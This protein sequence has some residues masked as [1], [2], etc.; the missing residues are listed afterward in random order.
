[1]CW[2]RAGQLHERVIL[3]SFI[4]SS[5]AESSIEYAEGRHRAHRHDAA[6]RQG[7]FRTAL[8]AAAL[9]FFGAMA[10]Q[11]AAADSYPSRPITLVVGFPP[12][13]GSDAVARVLGT[14][15]GAKLGQPIVVDNKPGAN[16]LIATQFVRARPN[17]GYTLLF[18]S[19]SFAINPSL[20]KVNY[21]IAKDFAPIALVG[22]VPLVFVANN[23]VPV[24]TVPEVVALLKAKPGQLT[25]ASFGSGSVAHLATEQFLSMTG[26]Q[27]LHVPYK[28]SAQA[29][30]DVMGGQVPFMM[31]TIGAAASLIKEGKLRAIGVSGA[32]RSPSLPNVPTIAESGV[33][34]FNLVT[35]ESVQAPAGTDP[36]IVA[37]LNAAIREVLSTAE[38][39]TQM[40]NLGLEAE[41]R[42]SPAEAA[43]FIQAEAANFKKL[44]KELDIKSD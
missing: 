34:G 21:D 40:L 33:P 42:K 35:W 20:Q 12:G 36:A 27:M 1:M 8:A 6:L 14:A 28:G 3:M 22:T 23:N 26:T 18:V 44:V 38:V 15:L 16:T 9:C 43:Q 7:A 19:A 25:Y 30:V 37:K 31:P 39:Q 4:K 11:A 29:I 24:K 17:D 32:T 5:K 41:S 13:G 2:R 10:P